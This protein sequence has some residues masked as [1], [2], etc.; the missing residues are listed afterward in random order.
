M[1]LVGSY[2]NHFNHF[3]NLFYWFYHFGISYHDFILLFTELNHCNIR[4]Q[5]QEQY[6]KKN[7]PP[8]SINE[9][10]ITILREMRNIFP[11]KNNES[12]LQA[13]KDL[14]TDEKFFATVVSI[15]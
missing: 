7:E 10:I 9:Q 12:F 15:V 8:S 13:D 11:L 1:L 6:Q 14:S 3:Y 2:S 5:L 4:R